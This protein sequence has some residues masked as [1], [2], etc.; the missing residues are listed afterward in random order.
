VKKNRIFRMDDET[1]E[2]LTAIAS[3]FGMKRAAVLRLFIHEKHALYRSHKMFRQ[4]K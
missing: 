4:T 3:R 2:K 1:Y